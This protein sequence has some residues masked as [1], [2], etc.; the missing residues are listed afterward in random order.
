[1]KDHHV[2]Q[3]G[4]PCTIGSALFRE[5]RPSA[6]SAAV[7]RLREA[8]FII[9][10]RTAMSELGILPTT[11][12]RLSGVTVNPWRAG[13][14]PGASSGGSAAAVAAGIVPLAHGGDGGGSL[15]VPAA[16]CGLMGLK[17]SWTHFTGV[18]GG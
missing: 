9:V 2:A 1:V 3:R 13:R 7:R 17:P 11:E 4:A 18:G 8:G 5:Y 6:E 14:T 16:C 15:P 10:G 12:P